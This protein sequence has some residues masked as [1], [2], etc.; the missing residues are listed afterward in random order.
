MKPYEQILHLV[1]GAIKAKALY[2]TEH[3]AFKKA[4]ANLLL[5]L[6]PFHDRR[7]EITVGVAED[8]LTCE[9]FALY[10]LP[11]ALQ[12]LLEQLLN[13]EVNVIRFKPGLTAE[14]II[15]WVDILDDAETNNQKGD[16]VSGELVMR[17]ISHITVELVS[18]DPT[19][20]YNDAISYVGSMF[21]EL[22]MGEIPRPDRAKG[23][24][25]AMTRCL[26]DNPSALL[27]LSM[28]KSYDNYL[29]NHSVNVAI[30]SLALANALDLKDPILSAVG[31]GGLLH[32]LGKIKVPKE[33]LQKPGR[34]SPAEWEKMKEHSVHSFEIIQKMN[35]LQE[36]TARC[37]L[38]HHVQYDL[39]GYPDLGPG[40]KPSPFSHIVAI[41]DCYDAITTLRVYQN[42]SG[43]REALVLMDKLAGTKLD[44]HYFERF[45]TMLGMYPVGSLIRLE[46]NE[47]A[48]VTG[49]NE[50]PD[51]PPKVKIIIDEFGNRL[52]QPIDLNLA[53]PLPASAPSRRIIGTVDPLLK[54]ID[55]TAYLK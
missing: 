39:K 54:N 19:K 5:A 38:E 42:Q 15:D 51:A 48:V 30:L 1:A 46:T 43:P 28:I 27:G 49:T 25:S 12:E 23:I 53:G 36:T 16:W 26:D 34:L 24:V 47:L 6:K 31:L 18:P 50:A 10:H 45:V 14:E 52:P 2:P 20:V 32:D 8:T 9:D 4:V 33:I 37:A 40:N 17:G 44:P 7:Q 41:A 35:S 13:I 29:F 21:H 22:R 55:V 3:P 11:A